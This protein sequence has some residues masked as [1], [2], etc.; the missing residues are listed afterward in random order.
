MNHR[1]KSKLGL[2]A[3][4]AAIAAVVVGVA[5]ATI[6]DSGGVIHSCYNAS[7][8]PSGALRVI[9]TTT[10]A[11]C[12]K[13]EKA[14]N[15]NQTGPQGPQGVKGVD[16][17]NG[18]NGTNGAPGAAGQAGPA[19]TSDAYLE[20]PAEDVNSGILSGGD[21]SEIAHL[22]VPAGNYEVAAKLHVYNTDRD[23]GVF[24]QLPGIDGA[25]AWFS[26]SDSHHA[27]QVTGATISLLGTVAFPQGGTI[28]LQCQTNEAGVRR[29]NTKILATKVSTLH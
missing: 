5:Y 19:G 14:L 1:I 16:G 11:I 7:A 17:T 9:D 25:A 10:G 20:V 12:S 24:C 15:F 21:F 3:L 18:T 6:P 2:T 29:D 26:Q 22:D 8:N 23:A 4:V 28:S 13:N 27:T